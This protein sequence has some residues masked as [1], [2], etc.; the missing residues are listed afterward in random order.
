MR[1]LLFILPALICAAAVLLSQAPA[2]QP[3]DR[4]TKEPG[5]DQKKDFSNAPLVIRMMAFN[6]KKD[7]KL[8][9]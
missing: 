6:K 4:P 2:R 3:G 1:K 7:G 8:T 5:K 9:K